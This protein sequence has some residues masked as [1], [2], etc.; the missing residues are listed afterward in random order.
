MRTIRASE[1]GTFLYC[2]RAW[3]Y[4]KLGNPS[5]HQ[6]Q[7]EEGSDFHLQ[8]GRKVAQA[9]WLRWMAALI[10]LVGLILMAIYITGKIAP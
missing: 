1:V 4:H 9:I 6:V 2:H 10:L 3:W 7:L 8:H 5:S